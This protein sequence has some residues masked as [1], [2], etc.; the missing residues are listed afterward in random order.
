M[1]NNSLLLKRLDEIGTSLKDSGKALALLG[2]GSV[3]TETHR[4]DN[5]SDLDFFVIV[6]PNQKQV[7]LESLWW[8]ESVQDISYQVRNT[9][10]GYKVLMSDDVF[11]EFA[12][13][14]ADE[15]DNI[16]FTA[17]RL[18][19]QDSQFDDACCTPKNCPEPQDTTDLDWVLGEALTNLYVAI[20]RYSRGE[21]LSAM[22]FCQSF[23]LDRLIDLVNRIETPKDGN[24]DV[25]VADRR[26]ENRY[27]NFAQSL[28]TFAQGYER[29]PQS[30]LAQLDFLDT[31]FNVNPAMRSLIIKL[32]SAKS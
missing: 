29:T 21:K 7:F 26:L 14:E 31:H 4:L 15:L 18:V 22:R 23:A 5:Y 27:P 9:V 25:F 3:G 12:V 10:D 19:W 28:P 8:L 20:C 32:C 30:I 17:G 24:I 16:P 1:P 2:L 11:C 6:K 13:F